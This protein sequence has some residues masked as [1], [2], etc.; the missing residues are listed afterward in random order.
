MG[1][2]SF[3]LLIAKLSPASMRA[4]FQPN[5][6]ALLTHEPPFTLPPPAEVL[7]TVAWAVSEEAPLENHRGTAPS[8]GSGGRE[9]EHAIDL[10]QL[11]GITL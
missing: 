9:T 1:A 7:D 2:D 6:A 10:S 11:T 4:A 5:F 8:A 3:I